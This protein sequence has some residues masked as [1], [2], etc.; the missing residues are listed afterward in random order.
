[1]F[2]FTTQNYS[3]SKQY[4]EELFGRLVEQFKLKDKVTEAV[5]SSKT[6]EIQKEIQAITH[7]C[8]EV[9][10]G[11]A[12]SKVQEKGLMALNQL[13]KTLK[14]IPGC[15]QDVEVIRTGPDRI[16]LSWKPPAHNPEAAE[17]YVVSMRVEGGA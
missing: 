16:K 9:A 6:L 3:K 2:Q 11:P 14:M 8:N 5:Q 15:P 4:C 12:A 1:M 17:L 13:E 10:V 7:H